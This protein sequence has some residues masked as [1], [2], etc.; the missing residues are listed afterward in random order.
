[1]FFITSRDRRGHD[2]LLPHKMFIVMIGGALGL[3]G[4]A[5]EQ[6][7]LVWA[8]IAVLAVVMVISLVQ[9][10]LETGRAESQRS[11]ERDKEI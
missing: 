11:S 2:P 5:F 4:M 8:A 10:R 1:M 6:S 7:W 3:A 9:R